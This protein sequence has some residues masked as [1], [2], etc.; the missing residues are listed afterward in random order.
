MFFWLSSHSNNWNIIKPQRLLRGWLKSSMKQAGSIACILNLLQ[1]HVGLLVYMTLIHHNYYI[2]TWKC[3]HIAHFFFQG[4]S[5]L[6]SW[7]LWK[8]HNTD[9]I[10]TKVATVPLK[11]SMAIQAFHSNMHHLSLNVY[12]YTYLRPS[13]LQFTLSLYTKASLDT[14]SFPYL[15]LKQVCWI[16]SGI[17]YVMLLCIFG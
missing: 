4:V 16:A 3:K 14:A 12:K 8:P 5:L 6:F 15:T 13:H 1:T 17:N 9:L 2:Q 7:S 11:G 10:R